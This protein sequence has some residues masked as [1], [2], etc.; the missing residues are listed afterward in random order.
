MNVISLKCHCKSNSC[1]YCFAPLEFVS[2][3][4]TNNLSWRE[5]L[6]LVAIW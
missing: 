5:A 4:C 3:K 2:D 1:T 6:R